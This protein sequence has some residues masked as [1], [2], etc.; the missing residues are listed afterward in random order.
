MYNYSLR[1]K[2]WFWAIYTR[3]LIL[4]LQVVLG[5][6]IPDFEHASPSNQFRW[7]KHERLGTVQVGNKE[8]HLD[9]HAEEQ[10]EYES[11]VVPETQDGQEFVDPMREFNLTSTVMD[12][13]RGG[14]PETDYYLHIANSGYT[15]ESCLGFMPLYPLLV[16]MTADGIYGLYSHD[17]QWLATWIP[18]TSLLQFSSIAVNC[19]V[20]VLANDRLYMLSRRVLKDEYLAYKSALFFA[21]SPASILHIS[22]LPDAVLACATFAAFNLVQK[23]GLCVWSGIYFA[24]ATATSVSGIPLGLLHVMHSSMRTVSKETILM[25]RN[26]KQAMTGASAGGGAKKGHHQS[27]QAAATKTSVADTLLN[28]TLSA[29]LPGLWNIILI[30]APFGALQWF[31][32]ATFCKSEGQKDQ[33]FLQHKLPKEISTYGKDNNLLMP[34]FFSKKAADW[35]SSEPPISYPSVVSKYWKFKDFM[36]TFNHSNE[37]WPFIIQA[38][39]VYGLIIWQ[40]R[41]FFSHNSRFCIRLGLI[42]N[43]QLGL[44]KVRQVRSSFAARSLSRDTFIYMIHAMGLVMVGAIFVPVQIAVRLILCSSPVIYWIAAL[45]TT[46]SEN[47]LVPIQDSQDEAVPQKVEKEKNLQSL[48]SSIILQENPSD[49][50]GNWVKLYFLVALFLGAVLHVNHYTFLI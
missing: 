29:L 16:R 13:L 17:I 37:D 8:E 48:Y 27:T 10:H 4:S 26:K 2:V 18:F 45:T 11:V 30:V 6:L 47:K 5:I 1:Q 33:Q 24:L 21:I 44:A 19:I 38:L 36:H 25:V 20:F 7:P 35:C 34:Y 9:E 41:A 31:G 43:A 42:D 39:P 22:P 14:R 3:L 40:M 50:L 46:P 32:H 12:T 28:I 49:E 15:F 23:A